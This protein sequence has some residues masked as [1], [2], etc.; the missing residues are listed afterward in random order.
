MSRQR[1]QLNCKVSGEITLEHAM[2]ARALLTHLWM[3]QHGY[4][5]GEI[6]VWQKDHPEIRKT[7]TFK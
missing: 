1:A 2:H 3:D 5:H 7:F 4:E 6:E